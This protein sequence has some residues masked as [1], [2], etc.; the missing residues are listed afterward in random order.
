MAQADSAAPGQR[1]S[2]PN[3]P[4][5]LIRLNATLLAGLAAV[6]VVLI[7]SLLLWGTEMGFPTTVST[8]EIE[9]SGGGSITLERTVR[10]ATSDAID[11]V[12]ERITKDGSWLFNGLSTAVDVVLILIENGLKWVPWAR[13][14]DRPCVAVLQHRWM[15]AVGVHGGRA[16]LRR[17]YG[18]VG[19][20]DR[21][22]RAHGGGGGHC[23]VERPPVGHSGIAESACRQ[24]DA[25]HSGCD[26]DHAQLRLSAAGHPVSL[27]LG[28]RPGY[29]PR[30][31][32]PFLP[33][34]G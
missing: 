9:T 10:E 14:C 16:A 28:S 7:V 12:V 34:S 25:P 27:A 30:S 3:K 29:S 2:A 26:A 4:L 1:T 32:T 31:S 13:Y 15:A 24:P 6:G 18:P 19:K 8:S 20:H 11:G 22:H 33:S 21:H 23:R 5:D 17:L